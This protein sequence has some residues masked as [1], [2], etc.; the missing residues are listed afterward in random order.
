M[1][2]GLNA[3]KVSKKPPLK[4]MKEKKAAKREKKSD[5][6]KPGFIDQKFN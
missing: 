2:K 4:T 3:K 6:N 5:K 1:S